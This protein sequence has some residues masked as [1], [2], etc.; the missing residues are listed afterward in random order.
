M[1]HETIPNYEPREITPGE[2]LEWTKELA[3]FSASEWTLKYY[4]RGAG[5]GFDVTA[6][7][8]GDTHAISVVA[9]AEMV[10]GAYYWQAWAEKGSE[11]HLV[12]RGES[13]CKR[14]FVSVTT[15]T[16]VDAR[17]TV[18]QILDAIDAMI[19][20]KATRDQQE[21][22]VNSGLGSGRQVKR[23]P[24]PDLIVLREH[25]ARL[26]AQE[27]RAARVNKG[28]SYFKNVGVRFSRPR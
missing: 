21:Y 12:A 15:A 28:G 19:L 4:F 17:S 27:L 7:A 23:I 1:S 11:K 5:P 20:G 13:K 10:E 22:V 25:Y 2:T 14:S 3:D 18:K 16:T 24:I 6:E 9:P 26:Y 8:S